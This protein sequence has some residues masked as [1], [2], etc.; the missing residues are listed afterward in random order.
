MAVIIRTRKIIRRSKAEEPPSRKG[1]GWIHQGGYPEDPSKPGYHLIEI[2][3]E[4]YCFRWSPRPHA[5][6]SNWD[7]GLWGCS[8][9]VMAAHDYIGECTP[10]YRTSSV[11]QDNQSFTRRI[12]RR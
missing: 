5:D 2:R 8:P 3:G 4:R 12:Y 1:T 11:P 10:V 7:C 6:S 9:S